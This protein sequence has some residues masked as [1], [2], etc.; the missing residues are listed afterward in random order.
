MSPLRASSQVF[1]SPDA[2]WMKYMGI[3]T[4]WKMSF[5]D[6]N[7]DFRLHIVKSV[8]CLDS[9]IEQDV[10]PAQGEGEPHEVSMHPA[11]LCVIE[12]IVLFHKLH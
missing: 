7:S 4:Q 8:S 3:N 1:S 5:W 9:Q 6:F 11:V 12:T 10:F 2:V